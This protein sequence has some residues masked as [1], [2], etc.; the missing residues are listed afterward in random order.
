[1]SYELEKSAV[2]LGLF[3]VA[4]VVFAFAPQQQKAWGIL[5]LLCSLVV[6]YLLIRDALR[7]NKHSGFSST[8]PIRAVHSNKQQDKMDDYLREKYQGLGL[9]EKGVVPRNKRLERDAA[10]FHGKV[11]GW[12]G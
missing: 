5:P 8:R 7:P 11:P 10:L 4:V 12:L 1:M 3:I 2:G 9:F 6:A